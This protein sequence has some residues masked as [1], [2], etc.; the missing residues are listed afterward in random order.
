MPTVLLVLSFPAGALAY[1]VAVQ[2]LSA[3]LP[4]QANTVL[5]LLIALFVA[6]LVMLPFLI[7]F[8]DHKAK[9]D[10]AAYRSLHPHGDDPVEPAEDGTESS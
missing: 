6:G 8:F 2:V 3:L 10:L 4:G 5:I 7:P 9:Q 1:A